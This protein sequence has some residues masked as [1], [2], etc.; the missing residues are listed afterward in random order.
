M[1]VVLL[2]DAAAAMDA[3][4]VEIHERVR[5]ILER[6]AHWPEV[7]GAKRLSGKLSGRWRMRTGD[8]RVQF[9]VESQRIVVERIGHRDRFYD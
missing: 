7:S 5:K 2:P 4:P 8:Y 6:L 9:F 1:E 3:L